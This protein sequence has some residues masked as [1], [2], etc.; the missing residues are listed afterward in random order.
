MTL[1]GRIIKTSIE[2]RGKIALKPY[3]AIHNQKRVLKQL[4]RKAQFTMF[5]EAYNFSGIL[6]NKNFLN[7]Y[8]AVVPVHDYD[9]IFSNWWNKCLH[10]KENV[11]WPGRVKYF[12]LSSGTSGSSSKHIPVTREM[13]RAIQKASLRQIISLARYELPVS[14]FEKGILMLGGSTHLHQHGSYFEGDLSGITASQIPF[15]FQHFYK[16]GRKIAQQHDWNGKLD[17]ITQ[18]AKDW[19][20]GIIVGVP[21]WVQLL[22]EKVIAHYNLNTIHDIWPNLSIYVHGGVSF[23]PYKKGFEK[24]LSKPLIYIETYLASE[25]FIAFQ[26]EPNSKSMRLILNNGIFYEFIPFNEE[27]FDGEGELKR[28]PK[29]ILIDE[30]R[31][32]EPYA[33]LLSTCS[34]A[35]RY[36]IGDVVTFTNAAKCE[37]QIV[38]RTKHFLSLCGE[39]LSVDNMNKA[40]EMV[41]D[42]LNITIGEFAVAGVPHDTLFAHKWYIGC[43]DT[44]NAS[45]LKTRIDETLKMLN[46]DYRVE[47]KSALKEIFVEVIPTSWFYKW[48]EMKGKIGAQNKFPRVLKNNAYQEW[49]T[50]L[51]MQKEEVGVK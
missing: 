40:V 16:P 11:C 22:I 31:E 38:G 3:S 2:L 12:A 45:E 6:G 26:V 36:L 9:S 7:K 33:I 19:D 51:K 20:I 17:E 28:K 30:V 5:G 42:E 50:Y 8:R 27:N 34:G 29:T 46:D 1:L 10:D 48:M 4:M 49:S 41:A 13:S 43:D 21:A 25:G 39:H 44:C 37:I 24:L 15:W 35:W 14:T 32:G 18:K 47:R 23:E